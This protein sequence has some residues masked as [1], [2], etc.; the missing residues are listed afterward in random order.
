MHFNNRTFKLTGRDLTLAFGFAAMFT[1][2]VVGILGLAEIAVEGII[3]VQI[4]DLEG[5]ARLWGEASRFLLAL[6]GISLVV[7][8]SAG[9]MSRWLEARRI[10]SEELTAENGETR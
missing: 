1:L 6:P 3:G 4:E 9:R 2:G 5:W 8:W 7:R 10:P